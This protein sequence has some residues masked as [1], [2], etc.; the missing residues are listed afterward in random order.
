VSTAAARQR[1]HSHRES[2]G[3]IVL[4]VETDEAALCAALVGGGFISP[5]DQDDRKKLEAGL[6][7]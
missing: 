4:A 2:N 1:L 7:P 6:A 3:R 5:N